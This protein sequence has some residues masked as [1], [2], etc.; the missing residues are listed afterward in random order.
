MQTSGSLIIISAPSGTGK[1]S[2]V[3]ALTKNLS[4]LRISVSHTTRIPRLGELNG[5]H[6][7]FISP[8]NFRDL[9]KA[10]M[11]LE[12]A[13]VFGN[14][15]GTSSEWVTKTLNSGDDV[16]LEIDWQGAQQIRKA[17]PDAVSIFILPPSEDIL[18]QRLR[19][20]G[21][22]TEEVI[23]RRI[24]QAAYE[25]SHSPE[26]DYLIVNDDFDTALNNLITIILAA[27]LRR[28]KQKN[29]HEKLMAQFCQKS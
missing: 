12:Q 11:F 28:S 17:V 5:E 21:Q 13:E 9:L 1:T 7:Y 25:V 3:S 27:R 15:Y 6:Y 22:D 4:K 18:L 24:L 8:E 2:L 29:L 14:Y 20:R 19:S 26:Y 23:Q 16:I 10:N